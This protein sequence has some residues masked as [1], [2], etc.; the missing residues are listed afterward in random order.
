MRC[1]PTLAFAALLAPGCFNPSESTIDTDT[2]TSGGTSGTASATMSST[3]TGSTTDPTTGST[4]TT[5][6]PT[7][8]SGTTGGGAP[9]WGEGEPPDFGDLGPEG[10]GAVLVVHALDTD[11]AVDVWVVGDTEPLATEVAQGGA[12]RLE[13]IPRDARRVV[14]AETGTLNAVGC[15]EWFPLRADE[16]WAVVSARESHTCPTPVTGGA[17]ITFE[18]ELPLSGNPLRF[19]HAGAPDDLQVLRNDTPEAGTLSPLGELAVN[20]LP[21]CGGGGC[22]VSYALRNSDLAVTRDYTFQAT[23]VADVPPAGEVLLVALGDIREDWPHEVAAQ[24]MLRVDIDAAVRPIGRDPEVAVFNLDFSGDVNFAVPS[25][26]STFVFATVPEC[27]PGGG[28]PCPSPVQRFAP[29]MQDFIVT[30]VGD[31]SIQEAHTLEGGRRYVLGFTTANGGSLVFWEDEFAHADQLVAT[32]RG[33]S[34]EDQGTT[35][36]IGRIF[37]GNGVPFDNFVDLASLEISMDDDLPTDGWDLTS[38][39]DGGV[40]QTGCFAPVSTDP[41]FRGLINPG[42]FVDLTAWPPQQSNLAYVCF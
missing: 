6:D 40:L 18:Q 3:G 2:E 41:G 10:E 14:L 9:D 7:E 22:R 36:T 28:A 15:S 26:P 23:Q 24:R 30:P 37:G 12:V 16:Q 42:L 1:W 17:S 35:L 34:L 39:T 11:A 8:T 20:D 29:G 21:D 38:A 25:P 5:T 13:G 27:P 19:V 33:L 4:S 32:G 31:S